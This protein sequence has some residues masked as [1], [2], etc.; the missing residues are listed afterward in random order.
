MS[1]GDVTCGLP[2][3]MEVPWHIYVHRVQSSGLNR[4]RR[5][6]T[7]SRGFIA[8]LISYPGL[9]H[10]FTYLNIFIQFSGVKI[11]TKIYR[12]NTP[13]ISAGN[14]DLKRTVQLVF[15]IK[16]LLL[17]S[18]YMPRIDFDFRQMFADLF[19]FK[20]EKT[21]SPADSDCIESIFKH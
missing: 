19:K 12:N 1:A 20:I 13:F 10:G 2:R 8:S 18:I 7:V 5:Q 4:G 3:L 15:S 16:Q 17:V 21:D 6:G 9:K 11:S 14:K